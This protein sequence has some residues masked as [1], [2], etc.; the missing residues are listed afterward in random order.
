MF[1]HESAIEYRQP[2]SEAI[3]G[4]TR[5]TGGVRVRAEAAALQRRL[6]A[7]RAVD[8]ALADSFPASDPPSWTSG[9]TH[10]QPAHH[11]IDAEIMGSDAGPAASLKSGVVDLSSP[12]RDGRTFL[13]GL[14]SLAGV[15]GIALLVP[16]AIL[17][18]ATPVALGVRSVVE[19]TSW[20][21]RLIV[22]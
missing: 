21:M 18:I 15:A 22:G 2:A 11:A 13:D 20:L 1:R 10:P 12:A 19:A 7:E 5:P 3:L 14:A 16:F 8:S 6:A 9:I 17:L 4:S